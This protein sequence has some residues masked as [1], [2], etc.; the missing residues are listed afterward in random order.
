LLLISSTPQ[1]L[2]WTAVETFPWLTLP[3]P[4]GTTPSIVPVEVN[5]AGLS[6]G[7]HVGQIRFSSGSA[8][9]MVPVWL[10]VTVEGER[11]LYLPVVRRP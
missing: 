3:T 9:R 4:S 8:V 7:I 5:I 1:E 2:E 11:P 10:V 6:P